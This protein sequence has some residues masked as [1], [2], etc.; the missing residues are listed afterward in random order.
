MTGV[1]WRPRRDCAADSCDVA[2]RRPVDMFFSE[3][4]GETCPECGAPILRIDGVASCGCG[5]VNA[6]RRDCL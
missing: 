4:D 6:G 5:Y 3:M 2:R 1:L